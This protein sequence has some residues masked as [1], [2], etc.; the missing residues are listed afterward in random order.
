M[1]VP[2]S[3]D[4]KYRLALGYDLPGIRGYASQC[5]FSL[6][7]VKNALENGAWS[8]SVA[9][10]FSSELHGMAENS[11]ND[12]DDAKDAVQHRYD[13]EPVQVPEDDWRANWWAS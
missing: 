2:D 6:D 8:S 10:T 1:H 9:D 4:N 12:G 3:V 5:G 13:N 11:G 7:Q